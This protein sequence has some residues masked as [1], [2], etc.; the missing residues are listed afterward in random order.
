M[1]ILLHEALNCPLKNTFRVLD[2]KLDS[3]SESATM[4]F[5]RGR[6]MTMSRMEL[7]KVKH[8]LRANSAVSTYCDF[9]RS[10]FNCMV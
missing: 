1:A 7:T 6:S 10:R 9:I 3:L 4:G 5:C 2:T 8:C